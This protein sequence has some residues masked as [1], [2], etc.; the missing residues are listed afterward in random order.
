MRPI[1]KFGLVI[2]I[3]LLNVSGEELG[4]KAVGADHA[5]P[6]VAGPDVKPRKKFN[7]VN[8]PKSYTHVFFT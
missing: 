5:V 3:L 8:V 4:L 6:P 7:N 1:K 2:F